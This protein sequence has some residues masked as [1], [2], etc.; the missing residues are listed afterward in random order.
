[1]RDLSPPRAALP[2]LG[3]GRLGAAA[4]PV[5]RQIAIAVIAERGA[6][7]RGV[8]VQA[9]AGVS[10]SRRDRRSPNQI[11]AA[12]RAGEAF[13]E[14]LPH[15]IGGEVISDFRPRAITR[16]GGRAGQIDVMQRISPRAE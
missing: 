5:I 7:D 4:L 14:D 8:L 6:G 9:I 12:E 10:I 1:V 11:L 2:H 3:G 15:A 13:T 16:R